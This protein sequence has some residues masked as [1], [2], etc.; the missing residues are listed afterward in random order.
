[1]AGVFACGRRSDGVLCRPDRC[2]GLH[3][4]RQHGLS[5]LAQRLTVGAST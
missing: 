1:L 5:R 2:S 3:L 4:G